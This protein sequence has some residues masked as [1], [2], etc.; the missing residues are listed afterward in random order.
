MNEFSEEKEPLFADCPSS[1]PD[2]TV[3]KETQ[4]SYKIA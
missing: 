3:Y 4:K 2:S 1:I